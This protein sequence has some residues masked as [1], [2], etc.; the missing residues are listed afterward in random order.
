MKQ[1]FILPREEQDGDY[2][3]TDFADLNNIIR[4]V[5]EEAKADLLQM[6]AIVRHDQLPPVRG[7]ETNLYLLFS[8]LVKMIL[9]HPPREGKLFIYIRA[10][11]KDPASVDRKVT[12]SIH[13]NTFY[14]LNWENTHA[15]V[16]LECGNLCKYCAGDFI[17]HLVSNTSC[18][19]TINLQGK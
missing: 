14:D 6:Q 9:Q 13:T 19:F 5:L 7:N 8:N 16:L 10:A 17:Y 18:L 11:D 1:P 2:L 15:A 3:K 4:D 12:I